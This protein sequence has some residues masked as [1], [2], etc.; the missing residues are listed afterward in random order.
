MSHWYVRLEGGPADGDDGMVDDL[1]AAIWACWCRRCREWHWDTK[2]SKGWE[3]YAKQSVDGDVQTARY[4]YNDASLTG[5]D[6]LDREAVGS[7]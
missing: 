3:F 2:R 6:M 5:I 4:V 1:P 7:A